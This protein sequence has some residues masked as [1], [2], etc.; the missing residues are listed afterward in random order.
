MNTLDLV[1]TEYRARLRG[2]AAL[3][4]TALVLAL[5]GVCLAGTRWAIGSLETSRR[6]EIQALDAAEAMALERRQRLDLLEA[7]RAHSRRQLTILDGLR[8]G[9]QSTQVF[10][11]VD[12]S[13]AQGIHFRDWSFRRAGQ[14]VNAG[15]KPTRQGYFLV[16]P[17][18]EEG[19]GENRAWR[20][21]THMEIQGRARDHATLAGF[22]SRLVDEP[23]IENVRVV[24]TRAN[25]A[26]LASAID[27]EL[28]VVVRT[29]A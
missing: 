27:F 11:A 10:F 4:L 6:A 17:L 21:E 1:P 19:E 3:R 29:G 8:G 18:E 24:Q 5:V 12:R 22:V 7:E 14:V 15:A 28:A 16:V 23:L 13:L 26:T 2:R 9:V 25:P 20:L